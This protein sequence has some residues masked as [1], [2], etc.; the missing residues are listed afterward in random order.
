MVFHDHPLGRTAPGSGLLRDLDL[1]GV[2]RLEVGS[3]FD[4]AYSGT[5]VP[6]LVD[7]LGVLARYDDLS[8]LLEVSGPWTASA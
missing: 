1:D 2:A 4:P 3:W 8:L 5:P 7:V 6:L